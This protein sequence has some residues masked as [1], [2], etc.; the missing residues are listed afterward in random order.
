MARTKDGVTRS[1]IVNKEVRQGCVMSP[2]LFNLY[3]AD[4]DRDLEKRG[5]GGVALGAKRIWSL[6]YADDMVLLAKNKIALDDMMCT[7]RKFL[8]ERKLEL[9]VDKTKVMIFNRKG[10]VG[11]EEW[12]WKGEKIEEVKNFKYLGFT[13]NKKG[14]Y[15]EHIQELKIRKDM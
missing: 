7:L 10:K 2:T 4:L 15:K 12:K 1:F 9:S 6:A 13:F 11:K 8:K 3:I 5:I 14:N